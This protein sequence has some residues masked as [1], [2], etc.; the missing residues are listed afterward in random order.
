MPRFKNVEWNLTGSVENANQP[1]NWEMVKIAV[2]MDIR[3]ELRELNGLLHCPNFRQIP[4]KLDAIG[5][6]TRPTPRE[7]KA[8]P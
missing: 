7:K 4:T 8:T 6:N 1:A 3:D 2:M 5:R